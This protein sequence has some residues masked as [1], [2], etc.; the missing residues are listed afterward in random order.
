MIGDGSILY[1]FYERYLHRNSLFT[2]PKK[3]FCRNLF[4][5][6]A[7]TS[8]VQTSVTD[9]L[10]GNLCSAQNVCVQAGTLMKKRIPCKKTLS[11][12]GP[13]SCFHVHSALQYPRIQKNRTKK[14]INLLV[15]IFYFSSELSRVCIKLFLEYPK[16]TQ[17]PK[18][19]PV[20]LRSYSQV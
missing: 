18:E 5:C 1:G 10:H 2:A 6:T 19:L 7:Q 9:F 14:G 11:V 3:I 16:H 15:C 13:L 17:Q 20:L 4:P 8:S 12:N